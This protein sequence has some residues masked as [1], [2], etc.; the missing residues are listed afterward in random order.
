MSANDG[1]NPLSEA[2]GETSQKTAGL[3]A[4]AMQL[5]AERERMRQPHGGSPSERA[6]RSV[7]K[8]P[9]SLVGRNGSEQDYLTAKRRW[10]PAFE[11][12]FNNSDPRTAMGVWIEATRHAEL[13]PSAGEARELADRR[14]R[15]LDPA[16]MD[17]VERQLGEGSGPFAALESAAREQLQLPEGRGLNAQL[18]A[19]ELDLERTRHVWGL[20]EAEALYD[21]QAEQLAGGGPVPYPGDQDLFRAEARVQELEAA[22]RGPGSEP[23]WAAPYVVTVFNADG[24]EGTHAEHALVGA[25]DVASQEAARPHVTEV[26]V[27]DANGKYVPHDAW[28]GIV[29]DYVKANSA[30]VDNEIASMGYDFAGGSWNGQTQEPA[31]DIE[32]SRYSITAFDPAIQSPEDIPRYYESHVTLAEAASRAQQFEDDGFRQVQIHDDVAERLVPRPDWDE[33][34]A[35]TQAYAQGQA[36]QG[37]AADERLAGLQQMATP[38]RPGTA[39]DERVEG[40]VNSGERFQLAENAQATGN[41]LI[42]ASYPHDIGSTISAAQSSKTIRPVSKATPQLNQ[43]PSRSL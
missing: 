26:F 28:Q 43:G 25:A 33:E 38:D 41:T 39:L 31:A 5:L 29:D 4:I 17:R 10:N 24:R 11:L 13:Y 23:A 40:L 27:Q 8:H 36:L 42:A 30:A 19:A 35:S 6:L 12:G 37:L 1:T 7:D 3:A 34:L 22:I 9:D 32:P 20:K 2:L 14:L 16:L 15:A 21:N 18:A